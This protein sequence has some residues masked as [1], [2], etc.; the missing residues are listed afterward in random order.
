MVNNNI[1]SAAEVGIGR[2]EQLRIVLQTMTER[3]G[4]AEIQDIYEAIENRMIEKGFRLSDQ[5]KATLRSYIN[6]DAVEAGYVFKENIGWKIT[7]KGRIFLNEVIEDDQDT[8]EIDTYG[9]GSIYPYDMPKEVDIREDPQTVFEWMRKLQK[10]QLITDPEFQRNLVWK[11]KQKALFLES[12]LL[13][14]PLPPLYVNQTVDGKYI[15]VDGLQRTSTLYEFILEDAFALQGLQVLTEL[16]GLRFSELSAE[17][18]AKIEDKKFFLYVIKPSVPLPMVYDIF[19]RINTG[20]TQLTRQ[21]IRN[22]FYIGEATRLLKEL[23]EQEYFKQAIDWGI[24][25]KRMKDR[26]AVLRYLAFKILDYKT[27]YKNDMDAFLGEAMKRIN[28]MTE[29]Q[30]DELRQDFERVMKLTFDFFGDKNFRLPTA[31]T[32]GRLNIALFESVSYFF[33]IKAD[34]FLQKHRKKILTNY[35]KLL[36]NKGFID[37]IRYSTNDTRKV[38]DRFNLAQ[39]ILGSV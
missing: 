1:A 25:D 3:D 20:G 10:G 5:G 22:C 24:S 29:K 6:R 7:D 37:A 14:I 39:E 13:N 26:E 35:E 9:D 8:E 11:P 33:S 21:E 31:S 19:H 38:I 12:V 16:N 2:T 30:I 36:N 4:I 32:R 18:Q 27:D 28:R 34:V 15:I 23:S 17:L